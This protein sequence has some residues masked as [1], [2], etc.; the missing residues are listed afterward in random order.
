MENQ[1]PDSVAESATYAKAHSASPASMLRCREIVLL[2]CAPLMGVACAMGPWSAEKI[3]PI[4]LFTVASLLLVAHIWTL[5]DWVDAALDGSSPKKTDVF[6]RRG[7]PR[8]AV[9]WLSLQLLVGSLAI[10]VLLPLRT[11][12]IAVALSVLGAIY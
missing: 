3:L 7:I 6:T 8:S 1:T 10:F 2:Q 9:L 11:F 12:L 5:N 4:G